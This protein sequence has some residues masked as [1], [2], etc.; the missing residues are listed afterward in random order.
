MDYFLQP[1]RRK[2]APVRT[3]TLPINQHDNIELSDAESTYDTASENENVGSDEDQDE[4]VDE[5]QTRVLAQRASGTTS[6]ATIATTTT[7][8]NQQPAV[9]QRGSAKQV[10]FKFGGGGERSAI[11]FRP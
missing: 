1:H 7:T 10:R 2:K 11:A 9:R 8:E 5:V 4:D 6:A 3:Q